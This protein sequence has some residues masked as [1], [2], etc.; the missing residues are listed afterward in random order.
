MKVCNRSCKSGVLILSP[1]YHPNVGGVET[2]LQNLTY[3]L[4]KI[5]VSTYVVTYMPLSGRA[6]A[7][8]YEKENCLEIWRAPWLKFDLFNKLEKFPLLEFLYLS[9]AFFILAFVFLCFKGRKIKTIHAHG[10]NAALVGLL[11]SRLFFKKIIV[12]IHA[13]YE[14]PPDSFFS[15]LTSYVLKSVD[16]VLTLSGASK[17]ELIRMGLSGD[18]IKVYTYWI[19]Q[20]I[21][22][23]TD[24]KSAKEKLGWPGKFIVL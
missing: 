1:F 16:A 17:N 13:I 23:V 9:P 10:L 14:K 11:L 5:A 20:E 19:E 18:K 7:K 12:S 6:P 24:K 15:R 2:H 8:F 3:Y 22:K 4:R 21:F